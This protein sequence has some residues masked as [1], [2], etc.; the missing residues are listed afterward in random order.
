MSTVLSTTAA[1]I[2][3]DAYF[4]VGAKDVYNPIAPEEQEVG[5][6]FLNSFIKYLQSRGVQLHTI[7]DIEIDLYGSKQSYTVGPGESYDVNTGRPMRIISARRRDADGYEIP[8]VEI[9]REDY[10]RLPLKSTVSPPT[11]YAFEKLA[12]YGVVYIWPI[13]DAANLAASDYTMIATIQRAIDIF[14]NGEDG[15]DL[16]P[17]MVLAIT[18]CLAD[19]LPIGTSQGRANVK[20]KAP[21]YLAQLLATD[22]ETTSI[23]IRQG[24]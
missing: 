18:Y 7:A 8:M 5:L 9:S 6:R 4:L 20:L 2:I 12:S 19:M 10:K 24:R 1:N 21:D 16:A 14:D 22:Q 13:S 15:G 23:I 17:E 3:S 11:Q